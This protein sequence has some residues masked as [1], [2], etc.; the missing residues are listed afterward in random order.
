[1]LHIHRAERA[2]VLVEALG[3]VLAEPLEDPMAPEIVSVPT[4][5][6]ER[7]LT[8]QLSGRLGV[9]PGRAD[10]VCANVQFPFPGRLVGAAVAAAAGLDSDTDPWLPERAVWPLLDVIEACLTEPWLADLAAHLGGVGPE[11]DPVRRT[12]RF[13]TARHI[14]DLYDRYG[15]HRPEMLLG[16]A[17]KGAG[18]GDADHWQAQLWRQLRRRIATPSPAERLD[19][20][21]AR[22]R[23][24][25]DLVALPRRLSLFGLTR[26][27]ASYLKV[28]SA[29]A[30]ERQVHLF[31]LHPSP[32][33]WDRVAKETAGLPRTVRRAEDPT[34]ALS[35]N[36]LL[37]LLGTGRPGD[38]A[39]AGGRR[40][41][42]G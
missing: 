31:L 35:R 38:A 1:M 21:C 15:V 6:I 32:D 41:L 14:A 9:V 22:L 11:Q 34:A 2:D 28:L 3:D 20:A 19:G 18:T 33:L 36:L 16:W 37:D 30:T 4:R 13:A 23:A 29:L 26:L 10:G 42:D 25:Q 7:W 24:E 27:P 12:R 17:A 39:G 5:G 8:Q 40:R